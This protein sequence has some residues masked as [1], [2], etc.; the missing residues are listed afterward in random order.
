MESMSNYLDI[1]GDKRRGSM[2]VEHLGREAYIH[3]NGPPLA[4]SDE[5][6]IGAMNRIFGPD[7]WNFVT[8]L[9]RSDSKVTK[10]LKGEKP[11][12]PFF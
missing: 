12:V 8:F 2:D 9:N 10:R 7:R 6:G 11:N 3:W 4:R 5:L 1:H